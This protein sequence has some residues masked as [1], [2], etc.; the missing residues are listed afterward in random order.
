MERKKIVAI[1][2]EGGTSPVLPSGEGALWVQGEGNRGSI[3]FGLS[4][5]SEDDA[6]RALRTAT[7]NLS[8]GLR[9]SIKEITIHIDG[10]TIDFSWPETFGTELRKLH[11]GE[12]I[13]SPSLAKIY[14]RMFLF[15]KV[16][17]D[18]KELFFLRGERG[19]PSRIR[20]LRPTHATLV[21]RAKEMKRLEELLEQIA[22]D[23]GQIV[24]IV[25]E[26]GIGKTRLLVALKEFLRNKSIPFA[27]GNYQARESHRPYLGFAEIVSNLVGGKIETLSRWEMTDVETD[28]LRLFLEP[29][30]KIERLA[31]LS[32]KD[33]REG[34]F[35]AVRRLIHSAARKP[36]VI[37]LEDLH[38]ADE[39]SIDLLE[40]VIEG[41]EGTRLLIVLA[42]RPD[43][44]IRWKKR[45][46][47]NEIALKP[48][49]SD[50]VENFLASS[51]G[52][53]RVAARVRNDLYK[54]SV[55][56]PLF[57]EEILRQFLDSGA[58]EI[59]KGEDGKKILRAK[60]TKLESVPPT[61]HSLIAARF[62]R[63]DP[64]LR[65]VL[66]W[67]SLLGGSFEAPELEDIVTKQIPSFD[68]KGMSELFDR[69]YLGEQ[70]VFPRKIYRFQHDLIL[71]VVRESLSEKESKIRHNVIVDVLAKRYE[72]Q[73]DFYVDRIA[74][75]ALG[76]K[77]RESA[78]K[79][80]L[81]AAERNT[82][83]FN[84][85]MAERFYRKA[86]ESSNSVELYQPWIRTLL[87]LGANEKALD[88][89][90]EWDAIGATQSV[91]MRGLFYLMAAEVYRTRSSYVDSLRMAELAIDAFGSNPKDEKNRLNAVQLR[92]NA[93][94]YLGK[95]NDVIHEGLRTL[96]GLGN[97]HPDIRFRI[98]GRISSLVLFR[99]ELEQ[100][101]E[102]LKKAEEIRDPSILPSDRIDLHLRSTAVKEQAMDYEGVIRH[103]NEAI[104][105]ARSSGMRGKAAWAGL[106]KA[107]AQAS[108]GQ[109]DAALR[110]SREVLKEAIQ[111]KDQQLQCQLEID[112]GHMLSDL[113]AI[114]EAE[115]IFASIA[116]IY[117]GL[118]TVWMR[119]QIMTAQAS[120]ATQRGEFVAAVKC[121]REVSEVYQSAGNKSM[122]ARRTA[123][124]LSVEASH[125]LCPV[126]VLADRYWALFEVMN[127]DTLPISK[128]SL[129]NTGLTLVAFGVPID[130]P[131]PDEYNPA[132]INLFF[133]KQRAYISLIH[134]LQHN[135]EARAK[136]TIAMYIE[137]RKAAAQNIP[138]EYQSSFLAHREYSPEANGF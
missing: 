62:D 115:K 121:L 31:G 128:I 125:Q 74:E 67:A 24:G 57:A 45:L 136:K 49:S 84:Y 20:G 97:S 21:G 138:R 137:W 6:L 18:E 48:L 113:G 133:L 33:I 1:G 98:W 123:L 91:Q 50:E 43:L 71:D 82:S 118:A 15:E 27:E 85:P 129:W 92:L 126:N 73:I 119:T 23:Q 61:L 72:D 90:R 110:E 112:R 56:N 58:L 88:A 75:H 69:G 35:H 68:K 81:Q 41:M 25:G 116:E 64:N 52:A 108:M 135:D 17:E 11:N 8:N 134:F 78:T 109:F 3:L 16:E 37:I 80:A 120:I 114:D 51:T 105:I 130:H 76:G 26:A 77:D 32:E 34:L 54:L 99:G 101:I 70:S 59:E 36:L 106:D 63:L 7:A 131:D 53:D 117:A 104:Q 66:R 79:W 96:R 89:L 65:N 44:F 107:S 42:H 28:F 60:E 83:L 29:G 19:R 127:T 13:V 38:W 47:Y 95:S 9:Q 102:F 124:A 86:I 46:N 40:R 14:D 12:A 5:R 122:A 2:V 94:T 111:L 39:G 100:G 30:T 103:M 132:K 4:E 22:V 87:F 55:G 93:L 10:T